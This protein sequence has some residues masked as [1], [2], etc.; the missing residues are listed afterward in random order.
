MKNNEISKCYEIKKN[1][2]NDVVAPNSRVK[3]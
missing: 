2:N 1:A 3:T